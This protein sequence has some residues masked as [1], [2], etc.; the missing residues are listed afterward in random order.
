MKPRVSDLKPK[1]AQR[2]KSIRKTPISRSPGRPGTDGEG[3]EA[4]RSLGG[5]RRGL[6]QTR[7]VAAAAY[8]QA[9]AQR[10]SIAR[11]DRKR[12]PPDR[13][14]SPDRQPGQIASG[15]RSGQRIDLSNT[16]ITAPFA[17]II[18]NRSVQ[19]GQLVKPGSVL[20]YL[21]PLDGLFVEA[22]FKETQI[23]R[24]RPGQP[25][26]IRVDA[27]PDLRFEGMVDSF[28]PASGSEFSLLPPENA[29]GNFTK[30]VRRV[31]VKIRFRPGT[32]V[33]LLRPGLSTIVKV[34][35]R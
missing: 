23:G 13:P 10:E 19:V 28:A 14:G 29:T 32:D 20:A 7:D 33:S 8:K 5:G 22:N 1:N 16:R 26:D 11:R 9:V 3:P 21:V 35:V 27:Y 24:M 18:G 25:A 12:K 6:G 31:P 4:L 15:G 17:G 2:R 34:K 30:I